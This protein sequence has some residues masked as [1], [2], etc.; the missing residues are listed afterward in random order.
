[1]IEIIEEKK[2]PTTIKVVGVGGGGS[3]ALDHMISTGIKGV[4]FIAANTDAQHLEASKATLKIQL[5]PKVTGGLGAGSI[6]DVGEKSANES[7]EMISDVLRGSDMVFIT[8]GMG[9]GTGTGSSPIIA[10]LAKELGILVV[11]VVT[12]PFGFEGPKRMEQAMSGI[13]RLVD[14]VDSLIIINNDN[15][16]KIASKKTSYIESFA[17]ANNV[18]RHAVQ[19]IAELVTGVGLIN[20]DFA[21]LRTVMSEKGRAIMGVGI[22]KGDN[23]SIDAVESAISSPLLENDS[24]E[25]ATGILI[26]I[27]GGNDITIHEVNQV[28]NT[29]TKVVDQNANVIYGQMIDPNMTD[30]LK[31]TIVA[32]GFKHREYNKEAVERKYKPLQL[33]IMAGK[34]FEK[35]A[36]K[37]YLKESIKDSSMGKEDKIVKEQ[38]KKEIDTTPQFLMNWDEENYDIPAYLRQKVEH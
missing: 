24:I 16:L 27:T 13:S 25:G 4:D 35:P 21:D 38:K 22:G 10:R 29:I 12:K 26:N 34:E 11:G 15:L 20:L 30:E 33:E 14:N 6:P 3:N 23:R 7:K 9:G 37:R 32:T 19:G 1:M 17:V 36:F 18:L 8:A 5:G 28:A 2:S 31:V